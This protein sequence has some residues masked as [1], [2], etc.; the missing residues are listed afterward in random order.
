M[1]RDTFKL[2]MSLT[3]TVL[4]EL[5]DEA[6]ALGEAGNTAE[7][8]RVQGDIDTIQGALDILASR[9]TDTF[10]GEDTGLDPV[11]VD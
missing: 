10:P 7:A 8:D 5:G 11:P 2:L 1:D 4:D 6:D 9:F 3:D